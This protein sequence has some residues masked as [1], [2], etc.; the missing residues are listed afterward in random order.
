MIFNGVHIVKKNHS[1]VGI[2][3][4]LEN[5]STD[6]YKP[7]PFWSINSKLEKSEIVRQI[8]EMHSY[9]L[10]GFVFHARTGLITEYLSEEWFDSVEVSLDTA[11]RLGMYV[12]IYDE[13]GWP[14]GFVGG[15]LLKDVENRA[16][17]L[18]YELLDEYDDSAYAVYEYTKEHGARL[19][20]GSEEISG[21]YHTIYKLQSDAYTDIL[22]PAVTKLFIAETHEKYYERFSSRFGKELVGFFTDE[23]QYF[24]YQTPIS[25]VT[26]EEYRAQYGK[27]L[28][29]G[30]LYLFLDDE[31]GYPFRVEYYNLTNRLYCENFYQLLMEWCEERGCLLTG[32]SVEETAFSTQMWGGAD[33]ATSYLYE[34]IP[35]IDNLEKS[36]TA[37]ISAKSVGS[38]AA[39]IGKKEIFTETFGVS[40][41]S[42]TPAQ[43]KLIA[44]KQ[45]VY[46]VNKMIQHLYNYSLAGQGKI[47]CPPSFGRT[48]PWVS[49]Y[50]QFNGYFEKIGYLIAHSEE[51]APVAVVTPMESVYLD[52]IRLDETATR[53]SVD[54]PFWQTLTE[55][56]R[57]GIAYHFVNEKIF[58]KIGSVKDGV[59]TVGKCTYKAVVLANCREL[60]KNTYCALE[61][62]VDDGGKLCVCGQA[63]KYVDGLPVEK[64][65]NGNCGIE[66]LPVPLKLTFDG[67]LSY[68]YRLF[69]GKRFLFIVNENADP[70]D[71]K[72]EKAFSR[73]DLA[74]NQGYIACTLHTV[75]AKG[76]ILLEECGEYTNTAERFEKSETFTPK[77]L[78]SNQ[79]NLTIEQVTVRLDDGEV[80]F[81][82]I[83]RVFDRLARSKYNGKLAVEFTFDSDIERPVVITRE[84]QDVYNVLFNDSPVSFRQ[85]EEDVNFEYAEV[86]ARVGENT[87]AYTV[88][89]G[90]LLVATE[91]LY[92]KGVPESL[93]NCATYHTGMEQIYVAGDFD[94]DGYSLKESSP[95]SAGDLTACGYSNF[96]GAVRYEIDL[97]K[98]I[99]EGY[100][101]PRGH[102]AQCVV[103]VGE[104]EYRCML[105][106][107]VHIKDVPAGKV[108]IDCYSTLRNRIGPFHFGSAEDDRI[109][110][111]TFTMLGFWN[112]VNENRFFYEPKRVV[113]F[114]LET[115]EIEFND[116]V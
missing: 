1:S 99:K 71:V 84:R 104:K 18:K 58:E 14:S 54:Y 24:R 25:S 75:P 23:P 57:A 92:K 35:A 91:I 40:G 2:L 21:K 61:K 98:P 12:W 30:L 64:S 36:L 22:N 69:E 45:Y 70:V 28:K 51:V 7:I 80:L 41:Y 86:H 37:E 106:D 115:V 103:I 16:S 17:Y 68:S 110:P 63:P 11:K 96:Y 66:D 5:A 85:S 47:D 78:S 10:G 59:F 26:E 97:K 65:L 90:K 55:L 107:G 15:K 50:S 93:L 88:D 81:G 116:E 105:E 46:G 111:A 108:L 77:F 34:H 33:C 48:M 60:K 62:Y 102:Y 43:L 44:D 79:N 4:L 38:V 76:S 74:E 3:D 89:F 31:K 52:Y 29:D 32:H 27:N 8:E 114:G 109:S 20:R 53:N 112:N 100:L 73:I 113:P 94:T 9:G 82:Y 19:L 39:Q 56:R 49:G 101:K 95:K 67:T 72:T 13:N 6:H 87:Y 83:Y 42:T